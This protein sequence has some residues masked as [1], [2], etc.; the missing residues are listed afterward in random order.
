NLAVQA[1]VLPYITTQPQDQSSVAGGDVL[2]TVTAA[3]TPPLRYQWR[4]NAADVIGA[5]NSNLTLH[6]VQLTNSGSYAV[7]VSNAYGSFLSS[8][9][10]LT[11][12]IPP[13]SSV[14][15]TN[16]SGGNWSIPT[17][18]SPNT[19]PGSNDNAFIIASG[20]YS[21]TLNANATVT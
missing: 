13:S 19:V 16:T 1:P 9:A 6:N 7:L 17:N 2:L 12:T 11:V 18:W 21:V 3:G 20:T 15:W 10:T 4:F 8:N 14:F 5:T